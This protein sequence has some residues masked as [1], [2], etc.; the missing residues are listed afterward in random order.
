MTIKTLSPHEADQLI[1]SE[2]AIL[3]DVREL[4]EVAMEYIQDSIH[5][6]L[7]KIH[8]DN[9]YEYEDKMIIMQCRSGIRSATACEII[10]A[11]SVDLTV[12]NLAGGIIEWKK[13]LLPVIS[14][15]IC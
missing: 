1:K 11:Q 3:I 15:Y 6:P 8:A 7:A 12:Y 2:L 13:Q 14:K 9:L 10:Q 5:I 4:E